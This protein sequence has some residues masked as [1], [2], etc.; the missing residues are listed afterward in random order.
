MRAPGGASI[1]M[2]GGAGPDRENCRG[3]SEAR[4]DSGSGMTCSE[5]R[6][7]LRRCLDPSNPLDARLIAQKAQP[8]IA[9]DATPKS[10]NIGDSVEFG[11]RQFIARATSPVVFA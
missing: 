11:V 5:E 2:S 9:G 6:V 1:D 4:C 7:P 3:V 8:S 10:K